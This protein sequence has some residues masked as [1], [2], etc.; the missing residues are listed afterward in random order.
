MLPGAFLVL[1]LAAAVEGLVF[2]PVLIARVAMAGGTLVALYD[3]PERSGLAR[4]ADMVGLTF[5]KA[6]ETIWRLLPTA[7]EKTAF[8]IRRSQ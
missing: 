7:P 4:S 6:S 8:P 1:F 2:A 5:S 3:S